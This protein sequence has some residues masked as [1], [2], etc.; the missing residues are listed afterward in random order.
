MQARVLL[1]HITRNVSEERILTM[2]AEAGLA[3]C[4][5]AE[6]LLNEG[7]GHFDCCALHGKCCKSNHVLGAEHRL[8]CYC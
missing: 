6:A 3:P 2:A 8:Q 4:E 1:C 7:R 5:E